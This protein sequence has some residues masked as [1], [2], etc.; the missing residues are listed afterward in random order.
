MIPKDGTHMFQWYDY[1]I[2]LAMLLISAAIGVYYGCFGTKQATPSEY[3]MG[4]R[5]MRKFPIAVSVAVSHFS[6]ITLLGIPADVYKFGASYWLTCISI[7]LVSLVAVCVYLPVLFRLQLVNTY[8]YLERRFDR[9]TKLLASFLYILGETLF[10]SIV[11][12]TPS[13][14]LAAVTGI[15]I[16]LIA[17]ATCVICIFYTSIGGM[18]T[19]VWTDFFQL[20]VILATLTAAC[21]VGVRSIGAFSLIWN[22]ALEGQRLDIFDFD[23]DPTKRDT[24]W[25]LVVG[26]T[27][28][29]I[30]YVSLHQSGVQKFLSVPTFR[31][32]IWSVFYFAIS[33]ALLATFCVA[34]GLLMYAEYGDCDPV[35]DHKITKYDQ[36]VPYYIMD[37][38]KH[39]PGVSG[40]FMAA[41]YS[42]ALSS[43]SSNLNASAGVIYH[44]F[45]KKIIPLTISVTGMTAGPLM[46]IF[47]L[48]MLFPK[49]NA[50]GAYFGGICGFITIASI[51][52]PA[53]YQQ[54]FIYPT[55]PLSSA[56]CLDELVLNVAN[57]TTT[58]Q[59]E[60]DLGFQQ[61]HFVFRISYYYHCLIGAV[62]TMVMGLVISRV[63]N[64]NG[65]PVNKALLSPV[66]HFLLKEVPDNDTRTAQQL[67]NIESD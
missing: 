35:L 3:L 45:I 52:V 6:A 39:I 67:M 56:G 58:V 60:T 24:F 8:E 65:R 37:V 22:R 51:V 23:L 50:K 55:K 41:I 49:A 63:T 4:N 53:R 34:I 42:A 20:A 5:K 1:I 62:V 64:E 54:Q 44:D 13:L 31:D 18:K 32:C 16:H 9:K 61:P 33:I 15:D 36:M 19:V 27:T 48:G 25:I 40:L 21:A 30:N 57:L 66:I 10:N 47:T 29:W 17:F 7:M 12:Y 43:L 46:G 38:A 14:A 11:A 59:Q 2:F 26:F 28:S